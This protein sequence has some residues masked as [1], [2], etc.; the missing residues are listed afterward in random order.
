P[1][2]CPCS[3]IAR[4]RIGSAR[5]T[6]SSTLGA[7]PDSPITQ[8]TLCPKGAATYQLAVKPSRIT[9]VWYRPPGATEWQTDK[10][11]DWAMDRIAELTKKTRDQT[12]QEFWEGNDETG[13]P[14]KKRVN[15]TLA[16]ASLGGATMNTDWNYVPCKLIR[17]LGA[18]VLQDQ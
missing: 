13:K 9:K 14:V 18:V 11:L 17:A 4:G 1:S 5:N 15:H 12:F 2:V 16:I 6:I 7:N 8:C 3:S 10:T